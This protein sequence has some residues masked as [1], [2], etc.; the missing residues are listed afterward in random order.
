MKVLETARAAAKA[1]TDAF[2]AIREQRAARFTAAYNAI[3]AQIDPIY[4]ELTRGSKNIAAVG[5]AYLRYAVNDD[6]CGYS[7]T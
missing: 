3:S 2:N 7:M 4:K 1:A 5:T 6:M